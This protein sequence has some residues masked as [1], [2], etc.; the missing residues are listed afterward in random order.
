MRSPTTN[1]TI[2]F[3]QSDTRFVD[4]N[5]P[6][7][8]RS[9]FARL[10]FLFVTLFLFLFTSGCGQDHT[11]SN[12]TT[13]TVRAAN[14]ALTEEDARSRS[15]RVSNI[16]YK[17]EFELDAESDDFTGRVEA[18]FDLSD[19][20]K[21][22]TL[23]F[24]GG[25]VNRVTLNETETTVDY[26]GYYITLSPIELRDGSNTLEIEFTHP[27]SND[28]SGLYRFRDPVDDLVYL[29]TDFEPYDANRLFPCFD[30]PDLKATYATTVT[31][32][33]DWEVI[34]IV[35][36]SDVEV[37]EERKRWRFPESAQISTYIYALHAGNYV[38]WHDNAGDI[39]LRLFARASMAG[40][41]E[42]EDWFTPTKQGFDFFQTYFDVPYPFGKYDQLIVPHFNA[43]AMENLGAVTYSER[44]L[45]RGKVTRAQ[46]RSLASVIM[47]EMAHMWFGN[48]V[49]MD[50][51]NG[52]W[53]NEAFATFLANL[54]LEEAT[55][56]HEVSLSAFRS[57]TA[58]YRA[59]ER[60]TTHSIEQPTPNTDAA[61]A[62]FDAI[63]YN[64]GSAVL[65]Q[66]RH[67]V[68][69]DKFRNGVSA[70]LK[71]HAYANTTIDDFLNSIA[72]SADMDLSNWSA[73]WLNQPGTNSVSV[74]Y[75]CEE[76]EVSSL[77]LHQSAPSEW[78]TLRTHRTQVGLYTFSNESV[79]QTVLP[80][81]YTGAQTDIPIKTIS[82][83]DAIYAN[84][85]NWD[86]VRVELDVN[87]MTELGRHINEFEDPLQRSM[88]WYSMYE[89]VLYQ[90]MS[91]IE[92]IRFTVQSLPG[93][94]NDDVTR[95]V[96][97]NMMSAWSYVRRLG[98]EG[99]IRATAELLEDFVWD[100]LMASEPGTDRQL[101][102]FDT[103]TSVV[104]SEAGLEHLA[105]F[106]TQD[107]VPV[108]VQFDQDRRWNVLQS[109]SSHS[110]PDTTLLLD[111]ESSNDTTD[112]GRLRT[113][114][115][116]AARP[117]R[118]NQK[119]IVALLL[120][121]PPELTVYEARAH[122]RGLFPFEQQEAQL[123]VTHEVFSRLQDLSDNVDSR[124]HGAI[125][126]GLLGNICDE[127]YLAQLE[128]AVNNASTLH[129]SMRKRLL[130][131]RFQVRRCI[132]IGKTMTAS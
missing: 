16:A 96:L 75:A 115:V 104:T 5:T 49:T 87:A 2:R 67:L 74:E 117:D 40:Y 12:P 86:F 102:L 30:Q 25:D 101:L 62:I 80:V 109:L 99:T 72:E 85:R 11:H 61:F 107:S 8:V 119:R 3:Q 83:P 53:L 82:C 120:D 106:L 34:S 116:Q 88:L 63:T 108:G 130:D 17:L 66:L 10:R 121:P 112:N 47:H 7:G 114:S 95:Q 105:K 1:R 28:G 118:A 129:P 41:V 91:P 68:G 60:D 71:R 13:S 113:L 39:P 58:A 77:V 48:L 56:F 22:L 100:L 125:V 21:P 45:T 54:A 123:Q 132:N 110:H 24:V 51:W 84:H 78:P 81:T 35:Q 9:L 27:Y 38:I 98:S 89:M 93:E 23:D 126:G 44:F 94:P 111:R 90:R 70:Y 43:G 55:E 92:F 122:A 65:A 31:V 14:A 26:N 76:D 37:L 131:M 6:Q 52:L 29:Y 128:V 69:P 36:E 19:A 42:T 64:K 33:A 103:Y 73:N 4:S 79:R 59:D 97:G 18:E 50:W 15:I 20:D 57:N 124:Y 127:G 32:P 46:R